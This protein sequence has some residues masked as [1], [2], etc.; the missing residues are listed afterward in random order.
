MAAYLPLSTCAKYG[1]RV[2]AGVE[3]KHLVAVD[4]LDA[5]IGQRDWEV[6]LMN[7]INTCRANNQPLLMAARTNPREMHCVLPD[8]ASRLLWGPDYRVHPVHDAQCIQ[9]M[10][11]RAHKRGFELPQHV[12]KYIERHYP[13]NMT[14]L[15]AMLD[16]LDA[17]SLTRGRQDHAGIHP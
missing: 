3:G 15:M 10:A 6:A 11:W 9:A 14:T 1:V 13:L 2:L 7:L 12:M 4:E 5:I 16:R 17:A 8:F